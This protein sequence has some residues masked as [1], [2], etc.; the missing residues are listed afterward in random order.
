MNNFISLENLNPEL[1]LELIDDAICYKKKKA[2]PNLSNHYISNLFFENSTRTKLSFEM[3]EKKTGME[4]IYFD[5]ESSSIKKG[6]TLYDTVKTLNSIGVECFVIRHIQDRFYEDLIHRL[7]IPIINAG[8]GCG[9]HPTQSLLDLVTIQEEFGSFKD[10]NITIVG[11]VV[12]SRV[13]HSDAK[14]LQR[15]GAKINFATP[16]FW[17]DSRMT[18]GSYTSLDS[19]IKETDVVMLLRNQNERHTQTYDESHF[20]EQYGL[21]KERANK[22]KPSAIIMHPAPINRNIEIDEDL[23][24]SRQSRI[25]TQ[26]TNG[27]FARIAVLNYVFNY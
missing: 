9:D 23:I 25:F 11:D 26:M 7:H 1:V 27:V 17:R 4:I 6:E 20:L 19:V 15:L 21:T 16:E 2:Y 14:I 24:E 5:A 8:D 18:M 10:L 12:H 13:A 22:M 3:A